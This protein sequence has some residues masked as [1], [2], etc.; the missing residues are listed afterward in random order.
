MPRDWLY[1]QLAK[2]FGGWPGDYRAREADDLEYW[3]GLLSME[4]HVQADREGLPPDE[5]MTC[6][7][8][9]TDEEI[10]ALNEEDE[11]ASGSTGER[12]AAASSIPGFARRP[13]SDELVLLGRR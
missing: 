9:L 7:D 1:V 4:A 2:M 13:G 12:G 10:A 11:D 5:M 3:V 8:Y 6:Y